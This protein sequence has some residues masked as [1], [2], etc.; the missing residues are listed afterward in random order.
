[1]NMRQP[2][3]EKSRGIDDLHDLHDLRLKTLLDGLVRATMRQAGQ[4]RTWT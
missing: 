2:G 1:M 3:L 4:R